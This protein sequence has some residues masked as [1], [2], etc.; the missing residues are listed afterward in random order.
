MGFF[1]KFKYP[2]I[3][4]DKKDVDLPWLINYKVNPSKDNPLLTDARRIYSDMNNYVFWD[5]DK[6]LEASEKWSK[7]A[8][9]TRKMFFGFMFR[10]KFGRWP[11]EDGSDATL[12]NLS[13]VIS[14]S[15]I[16]AYCKRQYPDVEKVT[17]KHF[18]M[19]MFEYM[20]SQTSPFPEDN[21]KRLKYYT[22]DCAE[23]MYI[24]DQETNECLYI[25]A[26]EEVPFFDIVKYDEY[27]GWVVDDVMPD[28]IKT[29][30]VPLKLTYDFERYYSLRNAYA[31][32]FAEITGMFPSFLQKANLSGLSLDDITTNTLN[33]ANIKSRYLE[34]MASDLI[35]IIEYM[36]R[37]ASKYME[38]RAQWEAFI[39]YSKQ[40][41]EKVCG[42]LK[43]GQK[44]SDNQAYIDYDKEALR[45]FDEFSKNDKVMNMTDEEF[46]E[47]V[48]EQKEKIAGLKQE[49]QDIKIA[50]KQTTQA[51]EI[52]SGQKKVVEGKEDIE[53]PEWMTQGKTP[54]EIEEMKESQRKFEAF[55]EKMEELKQK[56]MTDEQI[57]EWIYKH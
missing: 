12:Q 7:I 11:A 43:P 28:C 24:W 25:E 2:A 45:R 26:K 50:Q 55:K 44:E 32:R 41:R 20:A 6:C 52:L 9:G 18:F 17:D 5:S 38:Q 47:H 15:S 8:P 27:D 51:L 22:S 3:P 33:N 49:I 10:E 4:K 48:K 54:E 39:E 42:K 19:L 30:E 13:E 40:Q 46:E 21:E 53:L 36:N 35:K 16:E 1:S 57:N 37:D 29:S 23:F 34:Y 31:C 56:G 14:D